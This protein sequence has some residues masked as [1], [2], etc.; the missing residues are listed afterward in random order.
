ML[1]P[2]TFTMVNNSREI[3]NLFLCWQ[4]VC[5]QFSLEMKW[6]GWHC[7]HNTPKMH[8]TSLSGA[9]FTLNQATAS[10]W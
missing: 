7:T 6:N 10:I 4:Q 5:K 9:A 1:I 8:V 2:P 3:L